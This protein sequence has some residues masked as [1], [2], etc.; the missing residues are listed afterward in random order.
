[1]NM[2]KEIA[3]KYFLHLLRLLVF[4]AVLCIVVYGSYAYDECNKLENYT[5]NPWSTATIVSGGTYDSQYGTNASVQPIKSFQINF[6]NMV[7]SFLVAVATTLLIISLS[8]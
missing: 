6:L 5:D 2:N 1:M 7:T 3:F 4:A 8:K